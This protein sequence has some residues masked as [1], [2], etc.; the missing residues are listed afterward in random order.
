MFLLLLLLPHLLTISKG[1]GEPFLRRYLTFSPHRQS[2]ASLS[3]NAQGLELDVSASRCSPVHVR[4]CR[5]CADADK[6]EWA[7]M[8][9]WEPHDEAKPEAPRPRFALLSA[10]DVV[11]QAERAKMWRERNNT[12]D[13]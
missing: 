6:E 8:E 10:A 4:A 9:P 3:R 1:G 11:A 12:E 2:F 7:V 5:H 13:G